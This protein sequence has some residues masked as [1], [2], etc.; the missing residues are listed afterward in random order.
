MAATVGSNSPMIQVPLG[1]GVCVLAPRA[2]VGRQE[3]CS[4][5]MPGLEALWLPS[6]PGPPLDS[7]RDTV[8][9][10]KLPHIYDILS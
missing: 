5:Q 2:D 7:Q 1:V 4:L 6:A 8:P 3:Y 9:C 10:K